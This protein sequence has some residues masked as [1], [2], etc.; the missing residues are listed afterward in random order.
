VNF[1]KTSDVQNRHQE[2]TKH[3]RVRR[4]YNNKPDTSFLQGLADVTV[5]KDVTFDNMLKHSESSNQS[6]EKHLHHD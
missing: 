2:N 6:P 1:I 3:S 5:T 4:E